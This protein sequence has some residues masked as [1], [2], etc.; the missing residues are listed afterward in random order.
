MG[1]VVVLDRVL[2]LTQLERRDQSAGSNLGLDL[3]ALMV[4]VL[5]RIPLVSDMELSQSLCFQ[6]PPLGMGLSPASELTLIPQGLC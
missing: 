3:A 4:S 2:S 5:S 6:G 1:L